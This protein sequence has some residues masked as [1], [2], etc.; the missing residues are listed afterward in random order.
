MLLLYMAMRAEPQ[1]RTLMHPNIATGALFHPL[2][3]DLVRAQRA[4]IIGAM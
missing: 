4:H 2:R 3:D 1:V